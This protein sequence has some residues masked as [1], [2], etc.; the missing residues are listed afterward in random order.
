MRNVVVLINRIIFLFLIFFSL[1]LS[2]AENLKGIIDKAF[3]SSPLIRKMDSNI[4]VVQDAER[5]A[6]SYH[7]PVFNFS[8]SIMNTNDPVNVFAF[9]LQ[10]QDFKMSDFD[11][12]SLNKPSARTDNQSSFTLMVP[13]YAG[14]QI[15]DKTQALSLQKESME[16]Q[17]AWIKKVLRRNIYGIYY[18]IVNL[19]EMHSFLDEQNKYLANILRYMMLNQA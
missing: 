4:K 3:V 7:Y 10:Q 16:A 18:S 1:E 6:F 11:I 8:Q 12:N 19:D 9:K 17:K 2:S 13:I 15:V 5:M 14:G